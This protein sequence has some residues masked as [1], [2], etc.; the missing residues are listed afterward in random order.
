M[1]EAGSGLGR[2]VHR[3]NGLNGY[4]APGVFTY[5]GDGYVNRDEYGDAY[6]ER[7]HFICCRFSCKALADTS[8]L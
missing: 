3:G 4:G 7:R 1:P 2:W 6:A 8:M 5:N